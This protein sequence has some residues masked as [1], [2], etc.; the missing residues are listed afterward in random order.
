MERKGYPHYKEFPDY[1][2]WVRNA[3]ERAARFYEWLKSFSLYLS[4]DLDCP[5][6]Y[7]VWALQNPNPQVK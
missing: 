4:G 5:T 1:W 6:S 7:M 2:T 3:E